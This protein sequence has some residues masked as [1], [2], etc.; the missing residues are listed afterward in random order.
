MGPGT[1]RAWTE[2]TGAGGDLG[3]RGKL[4]LCVPGSLCKGAG[5]ERDNRRT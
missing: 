1:G 5:G 2:P 3:L 4:G